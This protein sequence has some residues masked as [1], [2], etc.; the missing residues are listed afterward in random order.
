MAAPVIGLN[1]DREHTPEGKARVVLGNDYLACVRAA[2]AVPM[3]LPPVDSRAALARQLERIDGLVLTG[4]DDY[5]PSLYGRRARPEVKLMPR[6]RERYDLALCRA[7]RARRMPIL[8]ICGGL[9]LMVIV[10]GGDLLVHLEGHRKVTHAVRIDP[11][12][13]LARIVG[14]SR[15][16]VNSFHHQAA[17]NPGK[18]LRPAAFAPDGCIEALDGPEDRFTVAVQWHPERMR[19]RATA[20][21]FAALARAAAGR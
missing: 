20:R 6:E 14:G 8:G 7:A 18:G 2:G 3:L 21:L 11:C 19:T 5:R 17:D 10:A 4:G 12:S 1:L 16:V 9:Q 15:L 13:R